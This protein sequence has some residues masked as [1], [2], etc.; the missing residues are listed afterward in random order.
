MP[1]FFNAKDYV[2]VQERITRFWREYP[3][4]AIRTRLDSDPSDFTTCRYRA[5]VYKD[6]TSAA[7][8]ATGYAFEVAGGKG[9][10]STSHEENCETSAIGRALANMGYATSG[11][12][13]P[14]R[15]EMEKA[16][17]APR[18]PQAAQQPHSASQGP[19]PTPDTSQPKKDPRWS[20]L[21]TTLHGMADHSFLHDV[22][23]QWG[24]QSF[25]HL[26][27]EKLQA[28]LGYFNGKGEQGGQQSFDAFL[29]KWETDKQKSARTKQTT[30]QGDLMPDVKAV[31][32]VSHSPTYN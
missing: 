18:A 31:P 11:K 24:F 19:N 21:N 10:N 2:D 30:T 16:Q 14:S 20:A 29:A 4:G 6:R 25:S 15:Q 12:D 3:E 7:P 1:G 23:V 13:R 8:D 17:N 28:L 26:P 27:V 9:A 22:A 32:N 5:E